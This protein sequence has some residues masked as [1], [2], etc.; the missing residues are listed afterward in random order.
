M[1]KTLNYIG[2]VV[3]M[4]VSALMMYVLEPY[5]RGNDIA[6]TVLTVIT[7]VPFVIGGGVIWL[8]YKMEKEKLKE[9][10]K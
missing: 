2:G 10:N 6:L 1:N 7:L 8:A 9:D 3:V 5:A 4:V